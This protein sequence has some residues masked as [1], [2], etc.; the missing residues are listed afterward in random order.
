MSNVLECLRELHS[1]DDEMS[2]QRLLYGIALTAISIVS[3]CVNA[4][5]LIVIIFTGAMDKF[6]RFYLLS[7]TL[8]GLVAVIP[9][10]SALLP[11]I[12]FNVHLGDPVNIIIS[13]TDTLGYLSLMM[14]TTAIAFDRFVFFLL[15]TVHKWSSG[16]NFVLPCFAAL[17]WVITVLLTTSMTFHGCY[18]RTDPY[19]LTFTYSCSVCSFYGPLLYYA[20]YVFPAINFVLYLFVYC[21][22]VAL[23]LELRSSMQRFLPA[24]S[25]KKHEVTLVRTLF[26]I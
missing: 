26:S 10:L 13:T 14:T 1:T 6:F 25:I 24:N 20:G 18:K 9:I 5:L 22:I 4:L 21:R 23:R 19:A 11:A 12:F 15:P 8:A 17:P 2:G 16:T 7:A 3:F